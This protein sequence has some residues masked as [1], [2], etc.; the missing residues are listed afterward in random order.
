GRGYRF[1][2]DV[3]DDA[4]STSARPAAA[5]ESMVVGRDRELAILQSALAAAHRGERQ[6]CFVT[7]DPGIGK[8]TLVDAFVE[9]LDPEDVVVLRGASIEQHGTPEAYA[10]VIE[11]LSGLRQSPHREHALTT[12]T[13]CA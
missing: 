6:M 10:P 3:I 11:M 7:G 4:P 2:A 5:S 13:R 8:T 12:L 9:G 1:A